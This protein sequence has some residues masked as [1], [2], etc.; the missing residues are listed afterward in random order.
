MNSYQSASGAAFGDT[1]YNVENVV[2][3]DGYNDSI[4]GNNV[5]NILSGNGGDDI[6]NGQG[7]DDI[8]NGGAV[9][10]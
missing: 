3:T 8:L 10:I 6:I 9:M 4:T 2:G 5:N 7:G 1:I